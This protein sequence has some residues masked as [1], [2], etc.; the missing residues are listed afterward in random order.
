MPELFEGLGVLEWTLLAASVALAGYSAWVA[1]D[2]RASMRF[3]A[4]RGHVTIGIGIGMA[5]L[6]VA[7]YLGRGMQP[8]DLVGA[9]ILVAAGLSRV[10]VRPGLGAHGV[11]GDG[12]RMGWKRIERI[13]AEAGAGCVVV[14][15]VTSRGQERAVRLPGADLE[16]VRAFLGDMRKVH[17]IND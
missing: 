9:C 13:A 14:R 5:V 10:L 6:G 1:V 11:Y 8:R 17:G 7:Y 3:T 4:A 16:G 15:Y 2:Q 12:F